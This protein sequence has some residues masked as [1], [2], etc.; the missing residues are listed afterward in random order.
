MHYGR[1]RFGVLQIINF[2]YDLKKQI[3]ISTLN[4]VSHLYT[5]IIS[6]RKG[7]SKLADITITVTSIFTKYGLCLQGTTTFCIPEGGTNTSFHIQSSLHAYS[8][9]NI[10]NFNTLDSPTRELGI[11]L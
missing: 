8:A 5:F 9:F 6:L 7:S 10:H 11:N 2:K 1:H 3:L 4:P